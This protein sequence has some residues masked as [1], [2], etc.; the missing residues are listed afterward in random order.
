MI[1][2]N[3]NIFT[4]FGEYEKASSAFQE[5]MR[6]LPYVPVS[7]LDECDARP[8]VEQCGANVIVHCA[9]GH[10]EIEEELPS[11]YKFLFISKRVDE[12]GEAHFTVHVAVKYKCDSC[13]MQEFRKK[14]N[15]AFNRMSWAHGLSAYNRTHSVD[16]ALKRLRITLDNPG[17]EICVSEKGG[18]I[19]P[20]GL[21]LQGQIVGLFD[22]DVWSSL[23]KN[24]ERTS[25]EISEW[26]FVGDCFD[27]FIEA[28]N[29]AWHRYF[30]GFLTQ[31]HCVGIWTKRSCPRNL[32]EALRKE[33]KRLDVP[34][35]RV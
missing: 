16:E 30:E 32:R 22:G 1:F 18:E 25:H 5:A 23:D 35:W 7:K 14:V 26:K 2:N 19:G 9:C 11:I 28:K 10:K 13:M 21:Y 20:F 24:G 3:Y 6:K 29:D 31:Y 12:E 15:P 8:L 27:K 17:W 33:A 34:F 4:N